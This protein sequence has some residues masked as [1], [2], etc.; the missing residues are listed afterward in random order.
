MKKN[1]FDNS[2]NWFHVPK[3]DISVKKNTYIYYALYIILLNKNFYFL[4]F[5]N[6]SFT[7]NEIIYI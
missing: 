5:L 7:F 6:N 3:V 1:N 2:E 4:I